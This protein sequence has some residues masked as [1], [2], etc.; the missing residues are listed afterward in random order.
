MTLSD[1]AKILCLSGAITPKD[2]KKAYRAAALKYHPD[3]NPAGEEMM[4]L[5][6]EA[7][8]VLKSFEGEL[9][10][11]SDDDYSEALNDALNAICSG[12]VILDT[13]INS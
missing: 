11:Q 12:Q 9:E 2:V 1:A 8:D 5:I 13:F 7:F 6:N 10:Q 3:K 4:K